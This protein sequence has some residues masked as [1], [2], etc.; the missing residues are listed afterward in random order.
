[1]TDLETTDG[2]PYSGC[3]VN[4]IIDVWAQANKW[5]NRINATL[6]GVQ[7]VG[8]G[9]RLAGGSVA[10]AEDFQAIPNTLSAKNA[11]MADVF[12]S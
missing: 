8:D 1:M 12:D 6:L 10:T 2:R 4:F 9:P 7:F 11:Q 3:Q 5:G